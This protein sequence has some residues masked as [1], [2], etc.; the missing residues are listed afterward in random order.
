MTANRGAW[1]GA[2]ALSASIRALWF[3]TGLLGVKRR[4]AAFLYDLHFAIGDPQ[5]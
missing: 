2:V 1:S 4:R 3:A 5:F